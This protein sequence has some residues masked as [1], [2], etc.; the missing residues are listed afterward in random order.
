[1]T[2]SIAT[3]SYTLKKR[4]RLSDQEVKRINWE[5]EFNMDAIEIVEERYRITYFLHGAITIEDLESRE[6]TIF[7]HP[8]KL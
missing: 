6:F 1:M 3:I 8:V 5:L 2:N 7:N 4:R